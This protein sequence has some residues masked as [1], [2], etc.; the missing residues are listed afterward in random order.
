MALLDSLRA[1]MRFRK[2]ELDP[3]ERR[4]ARAVGFQR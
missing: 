2:L 1:V 4:L 3:V